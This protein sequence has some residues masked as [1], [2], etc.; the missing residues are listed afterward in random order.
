MASFVLPASTNSIN[1][2][3]IIVREKRGLQVL[4][5]IVVKSFSYMKLKAF[6]IQTPT[7]ATSSPA[8][9]VF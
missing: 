6:H 1:T 5:D 3:E 7:Q 4:F 2:L 9:A 8:E